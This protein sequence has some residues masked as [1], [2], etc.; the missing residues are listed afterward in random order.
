[1]YIR[2]FWV[3]WDFI[4][5]TACLDRRIPCLCFVSLTPSSTCS[6]LFPF[7]GTGNGRQ[8]SINQCHCFQF[9]TVLYCPS[10]RRCDDLPFRTIFRIFF[11]SL[12]P[13]VPLVCHIFV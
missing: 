8:D 5:V 7:V 13:S 10:Q 9:Q 2:E 11:P 6:D 12:D 1:M 3:K 4:L